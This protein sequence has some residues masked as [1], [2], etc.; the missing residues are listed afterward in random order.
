MKQSLDDLRKSRAGGWTSVLLAV[1]A[2]TS[3]GGLLLQFYVGTLA[4]IALNRKPFRLVE[5][6]DGSTVE[7]K[8]TEHWE[9]QPET[10]ETFTRETVGLLFAWTG[11]T[12]DETGQLVPD[13]GVEISQDGKRRRLTTPAWQ[14]SFALAPEIQGAMQMKIAELTPPTVF[15]GSQDQVFLQIDHLSPPQ[16]VPGE[17][18]RWSQTLVGKLVHLQQ[19]R[20]AR[21]PVPFNKQI[22]LRAVDVPRASPVELSPLQA[23]IYEVR[24]AGLEIY[25][26][27]DFKPHGN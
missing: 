22:Y 15:E 11:Q 5:L 2:L 26:M 23:A 20:V 12:L 8:I 7:A 10:I 1:T 16:P 9:R 3:L 14:A 6:Q 19:G 25:K 4:T 13:A 27:Q 18:G 17:P 21:L 24:R